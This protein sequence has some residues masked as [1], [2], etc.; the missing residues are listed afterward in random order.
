MSVK[1][2]TLHFINR[3]DESNC[4]DR[5]ACPLLYYYDYFKQYRI[6]RHD[7]RFIEYD[8]ISDKDVVI[9]G[10]GGMFDYAEFTNR[11]IN[12]ALDTGAAVIAWSPGF[13]THT[14]YCGTFE[15]K[16]AFDRFATVSVRDFHNSYGLD[17]LPDITCKLPGL[18]EQYTVIREFGIACHKNYPIKGFSF[19]TI[20][21]DQKL[22]DI[23]RF[24]GE[25]EIVISN[26]FHMI[27]WSL[28]M[29]KRTI[30][31]DPFSSKFFSYKYKPE[32]YEPQKG[33]L[34][35]CVDRVQSHQILEECRAETDKFFERVKRLIEDR[36]DPMRDQWHGYELVSKEAVR[37]EELRETQTR[38]G[39]LLAPQLFIDTGDGFTEEQKLIAINS[40]YGDE[41]HTVRFNLSGFQTIQA[42]RFDPIESR[43]CQVEILSATT[44]AGDV[45]LQAQAAMRAGAW[46]KFLCTDPQYYISAPCSE[47]LEITFRLRL[48]TLFEAE[49]NVY[50]YVGHQ[51]EDVRRLRRQLEQKDGQISDQVAQL[52][53]RDVWITDLTAHLGQQDERLNGLAVKL[54]ERDIQLSSLAAELEERDVRLS[55]LTT[56]LRER[57]VRL[58]GLTVEL[59]ERDTRLDRLATELEMRSAQ[60]SDLTEQLVR[61]SEQA[62]Y[63][64]G[65]IERLY[66]SHS[67]KLTAPLRA[68][69]NFFRTLMKGDGKNGTQ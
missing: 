40:V 59:K 4:G 1:G 25:T 49:Q 68:I 66:H 31:A 50:S 47:F 54:R 3:L 45:P 37:W 6:V 42:L 61:T 19:D 65:E 30:C 46:D 64:A 16:I 43:S 51:E 39:D 53:Q 28:L 2:N 60:L 62:A 20:T 55:G 14:E 9:L 29:G 17:Y 24:I 21:N 12:R 18:E 69:V 57:E 67:W 58:S 10:G 41:A 35:D 15:T 26:S 5:V 22:E 13:N 7:M 32:Y 36:L 11:A 44:K 63:Q 34:R 8:R 52:G 56:K 27:Y 38:E 33:S 23:L 48:M